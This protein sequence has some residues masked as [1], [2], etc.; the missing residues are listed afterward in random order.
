MEEKLIVEFDVERT[1]D[2]EH[3]YKEKYLRYNGEP[4][5]YKAIIKD[6][7][8]IAL[9]K[10]GYKL[11]PNETFI[12]SIKSI[13]EE[14]QYRFASKIVG[15]RAV[16]IL[17][18]N[19]TSLMFTNSVDGTLAVQGFVLVGNAMFKSKS[20]YRRHTSNM[21]VLDELREYVET[22]EG[23]VEKWKTFYEQMHMTPID[24]KK[25]E[26]LKEMLENSR[27]PKKYT[28]SVLYGLVAKTLKSVGELYDVVSRQIW[29]AD[30]DIRTKITLYKELNDV[31]FMVMGVS[32]I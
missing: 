11:I 20:V 12:N 24:D 6:G 22:V 19:G 9:V 29:G 21:K 5:D 17:A 7:K 23:E 15:T 14:K 18:K 28:K 2:R 8:L 25:S 10:S 3:G 31:V 1:V 4:I 13:A 16:A 30:V 26:M 32:E 27:L